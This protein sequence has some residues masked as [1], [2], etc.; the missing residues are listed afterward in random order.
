MS[1][2]TDTP[3][4]HPT[5][6]N[7]IRHFFDDLDIDHMRTFG[8]DLATYEGVK[9]NALRIY[10]RTNEG[11]M[12]PDPNR[13]WSDARK[14]TFY[15]WLR[16]ECPRGTATPERLAGRADTVSRMRKNIAT[17]T[18]EEITKLKKSF[19]GIMDR[20]DDDPQSYFAIAGIHWLPGPNVYC[21]HHE[22]AYNPWHRAYLQLFEDTLRSVPG[23]EDVTLPYWDITADEIPSALYEPPL[24]KYTIKPELC[25]LVGQCYGP[26]HQTQRNT[27][28]ELL[29]EIEAFGIPA[30]IEEA[31]GHSHWE[32]FNGW[33][34]GRTQDGIIRAHDAGHAAGGPTLANQDV[35]AFD[36]I[37]WFFHANW[38]RLWWKWQQDYQAT[39]LNGFKSTLQGDSDWLDDPVINQIPPFEYSTADTIDL[40]S[41]FDATYSHPSPDPARALVPRFGRMTAAREIGVEFDRVSV[42]LS[43]VDR[44]AIPGSFEVHLYSGDKLLGRQGFFQSTDPKHCETCRNNAIASFDFAV[45]RTNLGEDKLRASILLRNRDGSRTLFPL[46]ACGNPTINVRLML[47]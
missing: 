29:N 38:D 24:D 46:V 20:D 31:L 40:E 9:F 13:Q 7:D 18:P 19:Q 42:R 27:A 15:N 11:T 10:I 5:Y 28:A 1:N 3:V 34:G 47:D 37:F 12:P 45:D 33:D 23:C 25:T 36:P 21:R 14:Q 43:R 30:N 2:G 22:N 44:L 16:D 26:N 6:M 8:I 41:T 32:R 4:E 17:L 39:T 35:A